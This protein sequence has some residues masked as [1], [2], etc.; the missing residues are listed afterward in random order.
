VTVATV[1]KKID[2]LIA[3]V[4]ERLPAPVPVKPPSRRLFASG[5]EDGV[6]IAPPD[7]KNFWGTGGWEDIVGTDRVSGYSWP[8]NLS[9]RDASRILVLTDPAVVDASQINAYEVSRIDSVTGYDGKPTRALY[10]AILQNKNGTQP[11]GTSPAQNEYVIQ[12][13]AEVTDLYM[14]YRVKFQPDMVEVMNGLADGPG[15]TGGGTWRAFFA[16]KTGTKKPNGYPGESLDN[17]DYRLEIYAMTYGGGKPYWQV[18][19]DNN[20]GANAPLKNDFVVQNRVLPVPVGAWFKFEI[21]WHRSA[22]ADGRIWVRID[23]TVI[24]DKTGPNMGALNLPINRILAPLL[25]S[26]S[27]MPIYQWIDDLEIWDGFPPGVPA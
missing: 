8:I 18:L 20:A 19:A 24:C 11:M 21:F 17:G 7:Q 10:Q 14:T 3:L 12:P 1:E 9:G 13:A 25:Y 5:F 15:V 23:G 22:G 26:G 4:N 6:N 16:F 2:A 27:R